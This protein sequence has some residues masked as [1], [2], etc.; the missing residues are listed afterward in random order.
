MQSTSV[1][2]LAFYFVRERKAVSNRVLSHSMPTANGYQRVT[3]M[4]TL[5]NMQMLSRLTRSHLGAAIRFAAG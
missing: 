2:R 1:L 5:I 4:C 3:V